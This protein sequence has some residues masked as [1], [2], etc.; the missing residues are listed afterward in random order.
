[1][2][3]LVAGAAAIGG[4]IR[5]HPKTKE[6]YVYLQPS[7]WGP[8]CGLWCDNWAVGQITE[9][10]FSGVPINVASAE[11]IIDRTVKV[12][13][14]GIFVSESENWSMVSSEQIHYR[15][16]EAINKERSS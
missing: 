14:D 4:F 5:T 1:M 8:L 6:N 10:T 16:Q 15:V 2:L 3:T 11:N 9:A 13:N 12:T 7:I